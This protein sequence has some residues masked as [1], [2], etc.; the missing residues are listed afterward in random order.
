MITGTDLIKYLDRW[1]REKTSITDEDLE[2]FFAQVRNMKM[3]P[4]FEMTVHFVRA[5]YYYLQ[6]NSIY[7]IHLSKAT[8]MLDFGQH[9][10]VFANFG[11][12]DDWEY[13]P[14]ENQSTNYT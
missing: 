1:P 12:L 13:V 5:L 3:K 8:A 2:I 11:K 7:S 4:N 9:N 10:V 14:D 6:G